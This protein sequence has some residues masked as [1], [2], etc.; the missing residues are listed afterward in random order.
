MIMLDKK[1]PN[2]CT[3]TRDPPR[4]GAVAVEAI[5]VP[6]FSQERDA[7]HVSMLLSLHPIGHNAKHSDRVFCPFVWLSRFVEG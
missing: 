1:V 3:Y 6:L 4:G 2:F 7:C 5:E